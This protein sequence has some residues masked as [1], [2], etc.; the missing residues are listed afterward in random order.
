MGNILLLGV[1]AWLVDY[2]RRF[3]GAVLNMTANGWFQ[4]GG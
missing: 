1:S 4:I 3:V 2:W